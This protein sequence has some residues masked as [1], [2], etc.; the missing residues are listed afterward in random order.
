LSQAEI[1][2]CPSGACSVDAHRKTAVV[3]QKVL[4]AQT[5]SYFHK[6]DVAHLPKGLYLV[7]VWD[8]EKWVAE[9]LVV[10]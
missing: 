2:H 6:I 4:K 9:K 1:T 10:R 8:G 3:L 7:R 5:T